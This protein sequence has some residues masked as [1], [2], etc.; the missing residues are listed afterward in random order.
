MYVKYGHLVYFM[1]LDLAEVSSLVVQTSL[2]VSAWAIG[3][4]ST[5]VFVLA[6]FAR[7]LPNKD[8]QLQPGT[9]LF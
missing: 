6:I 3:E 4:A 1:R 5:G 7:D 9:I 8:F 2:A